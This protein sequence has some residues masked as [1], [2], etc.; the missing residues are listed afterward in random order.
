[1]FVTKKSLLAHCSE[2]MPLLNTSFPLLKCYYK[3]YFNDITVL[4]STCIF[5]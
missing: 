3:Q 1:M 5:K 2:V 4:M